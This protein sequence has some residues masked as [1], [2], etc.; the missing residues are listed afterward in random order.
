MIKSK[1]L[2]IPILFVAFLLMGILL[3]VP[4]AQ[5]VLQWT[6]PSSPADSTERDEGNPDAGVNVDRVGLFVTSLYHLD[7]ADSTFEVDYWMWSLHPPGDNP[8]ES[9]EFFNAVE[10]D[11]NLRVNQERGDQV[12]SMSKVTSTVRHNW[13]TSNYPFDHQILEIDLGKTNANVTNAVYRADTENS[14]YDDQ[15]GLD[16]WRIDD[17]SLETRTVG[18]QSTFGD[19]D[20]STGSSY[21]HL[22]AL[23]ELQRSSFAGFFKLTVAAYAAFGMMLLS[24]RL[25]S[26][27]S[28]TF[29]ARIALLVGLLFS[30]V[31]NLLNS[32]T[33]LDSSKILSLMDGIHVVAMVYIFAAT[34]MAIISRTIF[35]QGKEELMH[36]YDLVGMYAFG[37]SFV[38]INV[39]LV[40]L[41]AATS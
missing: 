27:S 15:I 35:R 20:L 39:L 21:S 5:A 22:V 30:V 14:G 19:P 12:W 38:L 11:S 34:A 13:D 9:V 6:E 26:D 25:S 16:G 31:V 10:T 36:K 8:L 24:F 28:S 7:L 37:V 40:T 17:F 23:L 33:T 2:T 29:S 4:V 1:Q 32:N 3:P 41:A 18:Y